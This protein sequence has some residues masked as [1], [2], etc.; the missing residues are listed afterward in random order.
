MSPCDSSVDCARACSPWW[1][2]AAASLILSLSACAHPAPTPPPDLHSVKLAAAD[3]QLRA[4]C[5]ECLMSA[6]QEYEAVRGVPAAFDRAIVGIVRS[7]ALIALRQRELGMVEEGYAQ[8]ARDAA[9]MGPSAAAPLVQILDVIDAIPPATVGAGR[10]TSDADL[11]RMRIMRVN[12]AS[13]LDLL[14]AA[15]PGELVAAY[16]WLALNCASS[17]A[18]EMSRDD[19]LAPTAA[20]ADTSLLQYRRATCR[21]FEGS[22]LQALQT[23]EPRFREI[24][25][26]LGLDQVGLRRPDEAEV[27]FTRA[28]TWHKAWPSLTLSMAN[29]A[30]TAEDVERALAMYDATLMHEPRAMDALI[31]KVRA[32]TFLGRHEEAIASVDQLLAAN[33]YV[34]DARYWRAFNELQLTR[35]DDA[36]TDVEMA[37]TL[38][39][40]ADVPKLAGIIAYRRQELDVSR[41]NFEQARTRNADDCETLFYF[42]LVLAELGQWPQTAETSSA[43]GRCLQRAEE[44]A[45]AEIESI[46]MSTDPPPRQARKVARREQQIATARRMEATSWFNTAVAFYNTSRTADA[47]EYAGRVRDDE[48]FGERA[49]DLLSRLR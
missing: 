41:A 17:D 18:R 27:F 9:A 49:R 10:P 37:R 14:R 19:I 26:S 8:R 31:G 45:R 1:R 38:L 47:R 21:T 6:Y 40:N 5:L 3:A 35:Y 23:A 48:Q 24:D 13:W 29:V 22:T 7:A 28:Y 30:M 2:A 43:A 33:W 34:G 12:R 25:Y 36:W 11:E 44:Q 46:R 32:L 15:A 42:G 39:F 4:G 20:F 16:A